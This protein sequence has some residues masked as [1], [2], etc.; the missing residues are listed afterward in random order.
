PDGKPGTYS[1]VTMKSGVAILPIDRDGNVHLVR[2]FR[3]ALGK[4]SIEVVCGA[5]EEDEPPLEAA[6][7][8]IEEELGIKAEEWIALGAID[9]DTSIVNC[10]VHLFLAKQLTF[11]STHQEGTETIKSLKTSF[12]QAVK[13]VKDSEIT[14]APSC[15]LILKSFIEQV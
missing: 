12:N 5:L 14:H 6:K 13:M 4:E 11:T 3:Y 2:Q 7:R 10:P 8:E 1:T 15:I 9:L